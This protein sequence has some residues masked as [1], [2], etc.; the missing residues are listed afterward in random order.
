MQSDYI[1]I[2]I[3]KYQNNFPTSIY[4]TINQMV[5][6][7][8][9]VIYKIVLIQNRICILEEANRTISKRRKTKKI[10]IQ[11]KEIFN[12]QNANML[13]NAKEVDI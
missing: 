3:V 7:I 5:K 12:V 9:L 11:Q 2:R 10:R 4:K 1:K 6:S 8:Q 13:L